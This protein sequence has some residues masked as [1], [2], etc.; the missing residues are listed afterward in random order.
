MT[1]S[2]L[3]ANPSLVFED[4]GAVGNLP[5]KTPAIGLAWRS[6]KDRSEGRK[7]AVVCGVDSVDRNTHPDRAHACRPRQILSLSRP[8]RQ[9][10]HADRR[11]PGG[12]WSRSALYKLCSVSLLEGR[13]ARAWRIRGSRRGGG[14]RLGNLDR[15]RHVRSAPGEGG[16]R[17]PRHFCAYSTLYGTVQSLVKSLPS[18]RRPHL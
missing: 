9:S 7:R 16:E 12:P 6:E 3:G 8:F 5:P 10:C 17:E 15:S 14:G 4:V 11:G 18:S 1:T 13:A 2:H